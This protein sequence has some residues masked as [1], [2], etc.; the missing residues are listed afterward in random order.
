[1]EEKKKSMAQKTLEINSVITDQELERGEHPIGKYVHLS[2]ATHAWRGTLLAVTTTYFV[3]DPDRPVALV[4]VT[5][6]IGAY[7]KTGVGGSVEDAFDA[8]MK[9]AIGK[10]VVRVPINA[11]CW[12]IS[13]E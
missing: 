1:M 6:P 11:V 12:M 8:K 4:D 2:S 13:W 5:G 3:L 10:P 7:L 9:P